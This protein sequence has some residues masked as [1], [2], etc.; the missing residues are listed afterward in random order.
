[1]L[2]HLTGSVRPDI[3]MAM[4]VHQCA[5]FSSNPM[6]SHEQSVKRI[7]RYVLSSKDKGMIYAPDPNVDLKFGWMQILLEVGIRRKLVM[8]AMSTLVQASLFIMLAA[9]ST[10]KVNCKWKLHY[11]LQRLSILQCR[12]L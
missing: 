3:A 1:M 7:G 6:R 9:Q 12:K 2:T 10:D 4:A 5:R 8:Q 11:Q